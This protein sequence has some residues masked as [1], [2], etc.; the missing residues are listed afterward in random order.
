MY[1]VVDVETT[2]LPSKR[3]EKKYNPADVDAFNSARMLQIC[4]ALCDEHF[5]VQAVVSEYVRGHFTIR[6]S[7]I[8]GITPNMCKNATPAIEIFNKIDEL[9]CK[10][11]YIVAHN[12]EFDINVMLSEL[13]RLVPNHS[14]APRMIANMIAR[15]VFCSMIGTK[16]I[17]R[18]QGARGLKNPKLADLYKFALGRSM[19]NAHNAMHDVLNLCAALAVVHPRI[20]FA[21]DQSIFLSSK[22]SVPTVR[23]D[24]A[25]A[26]YTPGE[27]AVL[28]ALPEP[29][30]ELSDVSV[31]IVSSSLPTSTNAC[32]LV[33]DANA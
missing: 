29:I 8:H 12:A 11:K 26:N 2:G 5:N 30:S 25:D 10:S 27:S 32:P 3:G 14:D 9:V 17:V 28:D 18:A 23:D 15:K 16:N 20:E 31:D 7:Y 4:A 22:L 1:L 24:T 13:F 33:N 6:N 21:Q 19:D